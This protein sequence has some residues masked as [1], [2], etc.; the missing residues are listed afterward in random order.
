MSGIEYPSVD[1]IVY[2]NLNAVMGFAMCRAMLIPFCEPFCEYLYILKESNEIPQRR[3]PS[4]QV[5][6]CTLE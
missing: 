3:M 4:V 5:Y 1:N 6:S 2:R